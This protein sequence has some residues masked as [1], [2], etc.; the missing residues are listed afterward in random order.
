MDKANSIDLV[1][2]YK[3]FGH[4]EGWRETFPLIS[5]EEGVATH[6]VAAF[7]PK[8]AGVYPLRELYAACS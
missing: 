8:I 7:D 6:F 2:V 5:F 1:E 4:S 3:V